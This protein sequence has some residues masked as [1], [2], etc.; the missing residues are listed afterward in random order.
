M[1]DAGGSVKAKSLAQEADKLRRLLEVS[2]ST[3]H[4]CVAE[5]PHLLAEARRR[6]L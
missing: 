6:N 4:L 2:V 5:N 3:G 1:P